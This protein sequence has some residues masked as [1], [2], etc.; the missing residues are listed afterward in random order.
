MG[1][2]K[3]TYNDD[4]TSDSDVRVSDIDLDD[5]E[6][7]RSSTYHTNILHVPEPTSPEND[8]SDQKDT[9]PELEP[10]KQK[11]SFTP[12]EEQADRSSERPALK[13]DSRTPLKHIP[14][15]SFYPIN[16]IVPPKEPAVRG[17]RRRPT[18]IVCPTSLISHWCA[19]IDKHVEGFFL[20]YEGE[21]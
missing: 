3:V 8:L 7:P 19:E 13:R 5:D 12:K 4:G 16:R 18:L 2:V 11:P 20:L 6:I 17:N 10:E 21:N 15:T 1:L 9:K 14:S